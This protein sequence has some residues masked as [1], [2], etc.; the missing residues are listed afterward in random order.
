LQW[1]A[2]T[3]ALA[4]PFRLLECFEIPSTLF[5]GGH[6][7]CDVGQWTGEMREKITTRIGLIHI[8]FKQDQTSFRKTGLVF[9]FI[10]LWSL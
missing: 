2:T 7:F 6:S 5:I 8:G 1:L 10:T 9:D 3:R 4:L